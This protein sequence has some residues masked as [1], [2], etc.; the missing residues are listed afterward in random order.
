MTTFTPNTTA[1]VTG[2]SS[3]IGYA[4]TL[5]LA[6]NGV[7]VYAAARRED[8]LKELASHSNLIHPLVLDVTGSLAALETIV[9]QTPIDILVNNAGGALGLDPIDTAPESSWNGMIDVNVKALIAVTQVVAPGMKQRR[10]GDIVNIG[11]IAAFEYY[12]GGSVYCATKAAVAA[13]TK[14][15]RE[16]FLGTGIRVMGIHPGMADTEFSVV[17]F[18]GNVDRA[19]QVYRGTEPLVADDI[20]RA[21]VWS[22]SAPRHVT[23]ESMV[24]MPTAQ[25]SIW[26]VHRTG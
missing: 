17:R 7:T 25:S 18:G 16:D 1:L 8:R 21:I 2:A 15:W 24:L 22:L 13:L 19:Q 26:K 11:S 14:A 23:V 3:G 6:Q 10:R 9:A 12:G 5:M 4:T 20:A